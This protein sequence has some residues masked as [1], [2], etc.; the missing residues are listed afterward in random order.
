MKTLQKLKKKLKNAR[1]ADIS[2]MHDLFLIQL[3][4]LYDT[5]KQIAKALPKVIKNASHG[6]L[7]MALSHHLKETQGQI[8]RLEKI[9][10]LVDEPIK[11]KTSLG[12]KGLIDD[13]KE[14]INMKARP[15]LMDAA[16]I[17]N[18]LHIEHHEIAGYRVSIEWAKLLD[19]KQ[20][21]H[22]LETNLKEE[23]STDQKLTAL[24]QEKVNVK[25][26]ES[27]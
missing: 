9:F 13:G 8:E 6:N 26:I 20:A 3:R 11:G 2:S 21:A 22:F 19:Y 27:L 23:E 24:A 15:E 10:R 25:A 18:S 4:D 17:A 14:V 7:K 1:T 12:M 5:E 16:I